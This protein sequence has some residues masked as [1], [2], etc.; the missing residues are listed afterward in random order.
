[1]LKTATPGETAAP[2]VATTGGQRGRGRASR[3]TQPPQP[4]PRARVASKDPAT[5][6]A[7]SSTCVPSSRCI[8]WAGEAPEGS[9]EPTAATARSKTPTPDED[10]SWEKH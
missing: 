5:T 7:I 2:G 9:R 1:M 10:E 8:L 3:P 6:A 4:R